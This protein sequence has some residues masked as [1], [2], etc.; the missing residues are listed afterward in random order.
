MED[1]WTKTDLK[2]RGWT[3]SLIRRFLPE[4]DS[5][6]YSRYGYSCLYSASKVQSIE[7]STEFAEARAKAKV[8]QLAAKKAVKTK[9][10]QTRTMV[11]DI[12]LTVPQLEEAELVA[13][14]CQNYNSLGV[15]RGREEA[16]SQSDEAFLKR[17][18]VNYLR[19]RLSPYEEY[20]ESLYGRVG[21]KSAYG[22]IKQ[23]VLRAIADAYPYLAAECRNQG[24]DDCDSGDSA[25][26][27]EI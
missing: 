26:A 23:K 25:E 18:S 20:L 10:R 3:D 16:S 15:R 12:K 2:T 21:R 11:A 8:R 27:K 9:R 19:H 1:Q 4:P 13:Q 6:G 22:P 7:S 24:L 14:A 17:I 5:Y